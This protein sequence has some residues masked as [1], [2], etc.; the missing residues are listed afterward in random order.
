MKTK[1][2]GYSKVIVIENPVI[3]ISEASRLR[4]KA[5]N[6][7]NVHCFIRGNVVEAVD[8]EFVPRSEDIA[9]SY[10]P[11]DFS[12]FFYRSDMSEV[13]QVDLKRYAIFNGADVYLSDELPLYP[14]HAV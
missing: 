2:S 9:I 12:Y 14:L 1:V 7:K 6:Q 3:R 8:C 4:V 13:K 5:K 10:R 11:H